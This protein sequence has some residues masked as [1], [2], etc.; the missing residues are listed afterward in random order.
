MV[1]L[2]SVRTFGGAEITELDDTNV[3]KQAWGQN[4]LIVFTSRSI[5]HRNQSRN[6][7]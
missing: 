7:Q 4:R 6:Q 2:L 1:G 3:A 5:S